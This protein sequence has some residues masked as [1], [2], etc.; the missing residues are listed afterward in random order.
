M[1]KR[2]LGLCV[3]LGVIAGVACGESLSWYPFG[4]AYGTALITGDSSS[5]VTA[6]T[7]GSVTVTTSAA[8]TETVTTVNATNVT[9]AVD[10][11]ATRKVVG[12]QLWIGTTG[13]FTVVNTTNLAFIA[14]SITNVLDANI[15]AP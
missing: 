15:T 1:N 9:A 6:L 8:T 4:S 7:V 12:A 10:V 11:T 2:F 3:A 13:Y 5:Q 14:G